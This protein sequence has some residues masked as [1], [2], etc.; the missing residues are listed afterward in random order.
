MRVVFFIIGI[1]A[2]GLGIAG[3]FLPLVP[4]TPFLLLATYC[5]SKSHR[6]LYNWLIQHPFFGPPIRDWQQRHVI[7][8]KIKFVALVSLAIGVL[9]LWIKLPEGH[10]GLQWSSTLI[11][12]LIA[13]FIVTR[14]SS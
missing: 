10:R 6:G 8:L 4:T 13:V 11:M 1:A 3:I 7:R 5:F 9:V 12:A 14:K 2:V